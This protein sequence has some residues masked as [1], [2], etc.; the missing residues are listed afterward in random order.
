MVKEGVNNIVVHAADVPT[1]QK[2]HA[3]KTN[4]RDCRKIARALLN[5][6]LEALHVPSVKTQEDRSLVRLR[7]TFRK[8][9]TRQ[10]NRVKQMLNFYGKEI[11]ERFLTSTHWS[12]AFI[13]WLKEVK[14]ETGSAEQ[15]LKLLITQ[16][17]HLRNG[18]LFYCSKLFPFTTNYY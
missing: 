9:L 18:S 10:K 2:E 3:F 4:K 11:P 7:L 8:D 1:T 17:E 13:Q 12:R 6:E 5:K 16:V 15:A 14:F